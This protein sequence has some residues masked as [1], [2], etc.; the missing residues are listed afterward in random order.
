MNLSKREKSMLEGDH[1]EGIA[2]AMEILCALGE[3]YEAKEMVP[4][5]S[6]QVSGVSYKNLGD[7]GLEFLAEW[8][9]SGAYAQVPT[10]LNPAGMD[11]RQ[12]RRM[13]VSEEFAEKQLQVVKSFQAM[14]VTLSCTCTPYLAG[15]RPE[16]GSHVAWSESSAVSFANSVLGARTNRESGVSALASAICGCTPNYGYHL[17]ENRHVDYIVDVECSLDEDSDYGAL[18]HY[19]GKQVGSN[20][21]Y[22][23][24]FDNNPGEDDLKAL[25]AAMAASG[26]VAL[27]HVEGVT[28][29]AHGDMLSDD[30]ERI[31]VSNLDEAYSSLNSDVSEIDL[32]TLGCPHAS[33][34]ELKKI[35]D[36]LK[37]REVCS[38]LWVIT[39]R[40]IKEDNS[41]LV[42]EIESSGALV[43][44]DTCMVVAPVDELGYET[45]AT[46]SGK[47]A[48]YCPPHCDLKVRFGSLKECIEAALSGTWPTE[49][50]E[51]GKV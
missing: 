28:P 43:I 31:T 12:W 15:N 48:F 40:E 41:A 50:S 42:N 24:M 4:V 11:L 32:V 38:D 19:I 39:S 13:G 34:A 26:A 20:V 51:D 16:P 3:I 33:P 30:I 6:V 5:E 35:A 18:G 14:G 29:E 10:T 25:G 49:V 8:A 9:D 27:Y 23:H 1:G 21:P 2:K 22:F 45:M 17:D 47:A 44:A 37:G 46:N 7:A 36:L